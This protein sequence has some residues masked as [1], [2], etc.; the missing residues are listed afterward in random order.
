MLLV[1]HVVH[2]SVEEHHSGI[3]IHLCNVG[4]QYD[5]PDFVTTLYRNQ[6]PELVPDGSAPRGRPKDPDL[7]RAI[8]DAALDILRSSGLNGLTYVAVAERAGTTRPAIYRR[9]PDVTEL[10]VAAVASLAEATAPERTGDHLHDL[11][12]ELATFRS[13]ILEANGLS[14]TAVVLDE[15]TDPAIKNAYRTAVVTPRR[16]RI[17]EI[18]AAAAADGTISA[19]RAT[20]RLLVNMGTG[21]WYAHAVAGTAPPRDWPRRTATIILATAA[22]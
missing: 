1:G 20:Q 5:I 18:I 12:A 8:V 13:G 15:A 3:P 22:R 14:L 4:G 9:Y 7:E 10:A 11:T 17:A 21:S 19:D 6:Y 2:L 16:S